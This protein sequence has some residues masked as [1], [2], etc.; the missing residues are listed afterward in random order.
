MEPLR[1]SK[2]I[3]W[4]LQNRRKF[5]IQI[6]DQ[7]NLK[8]I[9]PNLFNVACTAQFGRQPVNGLGSSNTL[10]NA[11]EIALIEAIER[12]VMLRKGYPNSNGCAVHFSRRTAIENARHEFIERDAFLFHFYRSIPMI[13][14]MTDHLKIFGSPAKSMKQYLRHR[15]L[16]LRTYRMNSAVKDLH[17]Y[18][19]ILILNLKSGRF[20][21]AMGHGCSESKIAGIS[22]SINECLRRLN[23]NS[24]CLLDLDAITPEEFNKKHLNKKRF[25]VAEILDHAKLTRDAKYAME[26]YSK[27]F[28]EES[29]KSIGWQRPRLRVDDVGYISYEINYPEFRCLKLHFAKAYHPDLQD[30]FFGPTR[31]QKLNAN[32]IGMTKSDFLSQ[33]WSNRPHPL[34]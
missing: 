27:L 11:I 33:G 8:M 28:N 16:K 29:G 7:G 13:E 20:N 21:L 5:K 19:S 2:L 34:S 12:E 22:Q 26:I 32:R 23:P 30:L 24:D 10:M 25:G 3:K 4:A 17:A 15:G 9:C 6:L 31:F 1:H 14:I 18:T